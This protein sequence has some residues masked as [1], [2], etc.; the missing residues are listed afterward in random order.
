MDKTRLAL[1]LAWCP[2]LKCRE[3]ELLVEKLDNSESLT[4]LSIEDISRIL[5]RPVRTTRWNAKEIEQKVDRTQILMDRYRIGMVT[6]LSSRYPPTLRELHEP[7]FAIFWRGTL[8]DPELP[9]VA[10]VGTR[11]PSGTGALCA[12]RLGS[13]FA[14]FGIP[15]ASGLARGIDAFAHRGTVLSRGT[16]IAVLACGL[17]RIYPRSN[18]VLAGKILENGGCI[19]SEYPPG[20]DPLQFHFPQRNRLISGLSRSVI[21]VEA[22]E[23]SG[24]LITAD[25]ALEQ[26]RD[27]F[28]ARETLGSLRGNGTLSLYEQGAQPVD[29]AREV[30]DSWGFA[31]NDIPAMA[32]TIRRRAPG[33]GFPATNGGQGDFV[34]EKG[35]AGRDRKK[36]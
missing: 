27:L 12:Q 21:V 16:A 6:I 8:P 11:A 26:G 4:V 32:A 33:L 14:G 19:V 7:P 24:A 36:L 9:V 5:L 3:K 22:P 35:S 10:I 30:L 34:F 31:N 15:V 1:T 18:S 29:T 2:F 13:E 20:E 17:E 25:F 23:K 28:I